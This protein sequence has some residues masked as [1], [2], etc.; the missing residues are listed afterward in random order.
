MPNRLKWRLLNEVQRY[1]LHI[2]RIV[3]VDHLQSLLWVRDS[4][5]L[6]TAQFEDEFP[7]AHEVLLL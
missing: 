6:S 2:W 1:V 3:L 4:I 7:K 5:D